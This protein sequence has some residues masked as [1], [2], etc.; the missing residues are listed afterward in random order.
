[1]GVGRHICLQWKK[2]VEDYKHLMDT[3]VMELK[4][5][6]RE[7]SSQASSE[8]SFTFQE[9]SQSHEDENEIAEKVL[10]VKEKV[11]T[12][13]LSKSHEKFKN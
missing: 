4:R 7:N 11:N 2:D 12:E 13:K 3:K 6:V 1:M 9:E 10:N 5:A 8:E